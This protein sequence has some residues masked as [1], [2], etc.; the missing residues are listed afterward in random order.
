MNMM[1]N[2][3]IELLN[4]N[5]YDSWAV[6]MQAILITN[7]LW[8]FAGG[9]SMKPEPAEN[10][11][12]AAAIGQWDKND[13]KARSLIILSISLTEIKQ[14]KTCATARTIWQKLKENGGP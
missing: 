2:S 8:D 3:R 12:N 9:K 14:V 5:N 13:Q 10:N 1:N 6:Q 7:D 11:K 4:K